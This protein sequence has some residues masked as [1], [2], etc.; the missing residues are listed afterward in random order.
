[1]DVSEY[2]RRR[3][4]ALKAVKAHTKYNKQEVKEYYAT[5]KSYKQTME[6]F[7]MT[8]KGTLHWNLNN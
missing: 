2:K 5:C 6:H 7:G 8:S 1:M 4:R 3:R